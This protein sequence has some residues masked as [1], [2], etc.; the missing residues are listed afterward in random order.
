M[1]KLPKKLKN[2]LRR[3]RE[4]ASF[5]HK[6]ST[7]QSNRSES[8]QNADSVE[9]NANTD[10]IEFVNRSGSNQ[11]VDSVAVN[12]NA[13]NTEFVNHGKIS[14]LF[15]LFGLHLFVFSL[16][17]SCSYCSFYFVDWNEATMGWKST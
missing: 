7:E 12:A 17:D 10:N 11:N 1:D 6:K 9:V 13:D 15:L 3:M 8:I 16:W 4:P 5:S 14:H 2:Q